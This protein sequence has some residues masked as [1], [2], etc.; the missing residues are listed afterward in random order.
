VQNFQIGNAGTG[1]YTVDGINNKTLTL[2]RGQ[3]YFFT[4]NASG[5]PFW[6]K[7]A[8]TTGVT[9][10]YSTGVTNNGDD[11]GGIIFTVDAGA[12]ATLYYICQFHSPMTGIINIIG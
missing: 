8:Q 1:A 6:I 7:T 9:D 11:V 4:V 3:S 2:V 10:A 12:P 5:H